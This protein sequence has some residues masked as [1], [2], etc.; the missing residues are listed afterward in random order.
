MNVCGFLLRAR[1]FVGNQGPFKSSK[2]KHDQGGRG[3]SGSRGDFHLPPTCAIPDQAGSVRP[4]RSLNPHEEC[5]FAFEGGRFSTIDRGGQMR[6]IFGD[7]SLLVCW[8]NA[9]N[10]FYGHTP[11]VGR[12]DVGPVSGK[13]PRQNSDGCQQM[14]E[15]PDHFHIVPDTTCKGLHSIRNQCGFDGGASSRKETPGNLDMGDPV[16][17]D[18]AAGERKPHGALTIDL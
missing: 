2:R 10:R 9:R 4:L 16:V 7:P 6:S 5:D 14:R 1:R 12:M 11:G 15:G 13:V 17:L 3:G 8:C 18:S